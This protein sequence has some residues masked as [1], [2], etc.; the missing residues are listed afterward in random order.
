MPPQLVNLKR[1]MNPDRPQ[2]V[3]GGGGGDDHILLEIGDDL[4]LEDGSLILLEIA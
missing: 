4:L 1:L 2:P 3:G